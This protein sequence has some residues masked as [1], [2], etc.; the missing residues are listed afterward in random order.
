MSRRDGV[1]KLFINDLYRA[2]H[3]RCGVCGA[4]ITRSA[5]LDHDHDTDLDRGLLCIT[6]NVAEGAIKRSGLSVQAFADALIGYLKDPPVRR[7]RR[8]C[9]AIGDL[10]MG[11]IF[12]GN[13]FMLGEAEDRA[14][15]WSTEKK[16]ECVVVDVSENP[17]CRGG[18][19]AKVPV[20]NSKDV[21]TLQHSCNS[22]Q[23]VA[24]ANATSATPPLKRELHVAQ[25]AAKGSAT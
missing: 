11:L 13:Y 3:G 5:A 7:A 17:V 24:V 6:C 16:H 8:G 25:V 21:A 9:W 2:Q 19:F 23:Q 1:S 15:W 12:D 18:R 22:L 20:K 4:D 14:A 10:Q